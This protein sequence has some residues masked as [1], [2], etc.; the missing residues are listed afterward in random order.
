MR[1]R[2]K[3]KKTDMPVLAAAKFDKIKFIGIWPCGNNMMNYLKT[4][5]KINFKLFS[6]CFN[7]PFKV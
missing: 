3:P 4:F 1:V 5:S 6:S 7:S 2:P